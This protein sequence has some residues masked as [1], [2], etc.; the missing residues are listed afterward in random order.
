MFFSNPGLTW[1]LTRQYPRHDDVV[2]YPFSFN[3]LFRAYE[4]SV[5][6]NKA[7]LNPYF[8][9]G[10]VWG[11]GWLNS[12]EICCWTSFLS[13]LGNMQQCRQ[14]ESLIHVKQK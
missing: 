1:E 2:V 9:G 14:I 10:Y 13:F 5:S 12:H 4:P 8:W 11:G 7:L 3:L 6:L